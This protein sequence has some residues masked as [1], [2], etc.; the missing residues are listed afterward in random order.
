MGME[1]GDPL[2]RSAIDKVV[3]NVKNRF[4]GN[5]VLSITGP[6]MMATAYSKIEDR[7]IRYSVSLI[8][9]RGKIVDQNTDVINY[10]NGEYRRM[11]R[12]IINEKYSWLWRTRRVYNLRDDE[13]EEKIIEYES[14]DEDNGSTGEDGNSGE[15]GSTEEYGNSGEISDGGSDEDND[16]SG[17]NMVHKEDNGA[18]TSSSSSS[19]VEEENKKKKI[20][21]K[22]IK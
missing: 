7:K 18:I 17:D 1:K 4:Y 16:D 10:H 14:E 13:L 9:E 22:I 20:I 8:L 12:F 21:L 6:A 5:G 19:V 11:Q 3:E 15:N 2:M